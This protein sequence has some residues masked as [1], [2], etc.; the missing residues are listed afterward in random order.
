M[1]V[2]QTM[3]L[4]SDEAPLTP[5]GGYSCNL[6]KPLMRCRWAGVDTS[7]AGSGVGHTPI[8]GVPAGGKVAEEAEGEVPRGTALPLRTGDGVL[9]D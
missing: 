1:T 3:M 8:S 9:M 2:F 5:A 6:L 4:V 7:L